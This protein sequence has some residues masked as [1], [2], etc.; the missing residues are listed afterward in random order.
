[1]DPDESLLGQV[2]GFGLILGHPQQVVVDRVSVFA[3][4]L[5]KMQRL[6]ALVL[7][8]SRRCARQDLTPFPFC[9]TG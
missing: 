3:K 7:H 2:L 8:F 5:S 9:L 6:A 4:N 1:M